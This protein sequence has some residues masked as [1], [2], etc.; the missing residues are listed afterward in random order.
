MWF[1]TISLFPEIS[2]MNCY[3]THFCN[4]LPRFVTIFL[5]FP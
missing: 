3:E 4:L 2:I 1:D 5:W